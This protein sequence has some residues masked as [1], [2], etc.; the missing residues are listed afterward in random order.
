[1]HYSIVDFIQNCE[2][3]QKDF[4]VRSV[5]GS[6]GIEGSTLSTTE[7]YSILYEKNNKMQNISARDVYETNNLK[8]ATMFMLSLAQNKE[9]LDHNNIL[10][11]NQI[12]NENMDL[13]YIGGYRLG[14]MRIIGSDKKFPFPIEL[15]DLMNDYIIKYNKL[16]TKDT[17]TLKEIAQSHI[18][19]INIHPFPDGNGRTGR[20]LMNY[21]LISHDMTPLVVET[22]S[23]ETYLNIMKEENVNKLSEFIY[24]CQQK[25]YELIQDTL[26]MDM[27]KNIE[28]DLKPPRNIKMT[29]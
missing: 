8:N 9:M 29:R 3:Y 2:F 27:H 6:N 18:D 1:M 22:S 10:T 19:F 24:E 17:I 14:N 12:I 23:K 4:I 7:T 26:L 21:L 25:E 11:I 5:N 28:L 15:D 13:G 20:L 16:L